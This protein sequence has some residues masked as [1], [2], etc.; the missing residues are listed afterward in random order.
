MSLMLLGFDWD[1][2]IRMFSDAF[3]DAD[4]TVSRGG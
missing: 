1:E 3:L 4:L 2:V